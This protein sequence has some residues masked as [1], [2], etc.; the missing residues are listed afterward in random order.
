M[1]EVCDMKGKY[2][3]AVHVNIV[4]VAYGMSTGF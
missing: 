2:P 4:L 3:F 1:P